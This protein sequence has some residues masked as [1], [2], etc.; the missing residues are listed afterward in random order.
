MSDNKEIVGWAELDVGG[1]VF[2]GFAKDCK[3]TIPAD[4]VPLK[5][6][7]AE[8]AWLS[9]DEVEVVTDPNEG[10][11]LYMSLTAKGFEKVFREMRETWEKTSS[12]KK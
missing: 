12:G 10:I 2:R 5:F 4:G 8:I 3:I 9:E 1:T 11:I 7:H 6:N